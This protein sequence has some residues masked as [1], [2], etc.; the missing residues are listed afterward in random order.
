MEN[1]VQ[2]MSL[3]C[4]IQIVFLLGSGAVIPE[5]M[6]WE[7]MI[8]S[9]NDSIVEELLIIVIITTAVNAYSK[10]KCKK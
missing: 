1:S 10:G 9:S 7:D 3:S 8:V 5:E 2:K 4:K 6:L